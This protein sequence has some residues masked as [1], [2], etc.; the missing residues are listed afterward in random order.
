M[1]GP[2][3]KIQGT[4]GKITGKNAAGPNPYRQQIIQ[5]GPNQSFSTGLPQEARV[6]PK[7]QPSTGPRTGKPAGGYKRT[8]STTSQ[9]GTPLKPTPTG[10]LKYTNGYTKLVS[11]KQNAKPASSNPKLKTQGAKAS[12]PVNKT[13]RNIKK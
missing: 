11:A 6:A 8:V 5:G 7:S 2:K 4:T 1:A 9:T 10:G 12:K 3:K 13:M